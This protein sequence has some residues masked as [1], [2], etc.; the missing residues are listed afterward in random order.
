MRMLRYHVTSPFVLLWRTIEV[1]VMIELAARQG[2][3]LQE[4]VDLDV[5]CGNGVLGNALIR[6][7]TTGFDLSASGVTWAQG[8]KP[9]YRSLLRASAT[10]VPLRTGSQRLIFSNSVIEHIP[11][12]EG[13]FDEIARLLPPGGYVIL[14]TVSEQFPALMLGQ[15]QP[16]AR[17]RNQLN[18]SY[19]HYHYL[20]PTKLHD[21]M[22]TRGLQLLETATY[23]NARQAR[24]CYQLRCWEQGHSHTGM[25]G[26]ID[27]LRRAPIGLASLS[28]VLP[29]IALPG[30]G[31]GLAMI[32]RRP[33]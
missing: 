9:A 31:A 33:A 32:A 20:S 17:D 11:D 6:D 21:A 13:A 30:E 7:I 29:L 27:Q 5:G 16:N 8:H 15:E 18:R 19:D 14:S 28:R 26:R 22:A 2:I 12:I 10:S 23:I 25:A 3:D 4:H 24:W 1:A